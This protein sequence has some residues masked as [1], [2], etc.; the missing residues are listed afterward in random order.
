MYLIFLTHLHF[1]TAY[2][3]QSLLFSP[4]DLRIPSRLSFL[5]QPSGYINQSPERQLLYDYA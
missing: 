3:P 2:I 1:V 5:M 4:K